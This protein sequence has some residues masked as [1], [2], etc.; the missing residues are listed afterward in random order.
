MEMEFECDGKLVKGYIP[1]YVCCPCNCGGSEP[2]PVTGIEV[3]PETAA[4]HVGD[5][6]QLTAT[7]SPANATDKRVT[8]SSSDPTVATV[9]A[10]GKVTAVS[11]GTVV[12][13][14]TTRD[15][16]HSASCTVTV[17]EKGGPGPEDPHFPEEG[18]INLY[19]GEALLGTYDT[20]EETYWDATDGDTMYFGEGT[21]VCDK[22]TEPTR[23]TNPPLGTTKAITLCGIAGKTIL[24]VRSDITGGSYNSLFHTTD[25]ESPTSQIAAVYRGF[26]FNYRRSEGGASHNHSIFMY[27]SGITVENCV[28][29]T[30]GTTSPAIAYYNYGRGHNNT[31]KNCTFVSEQPFQKSWTGAEKVDMY[32]CAFNVAMPA[33]IS[34]TG[35]NTGIFG[36]SVD[37]N[38]YKLNDADNSQYGVYSG[39]HAWPNP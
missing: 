18:R 30:P 10:N 17:S 7:V 8:W 32:N 37:Q 38:N 29:K 19:R 15:G 31:V 21:F 20:Y 24:E 14:A 11:E 4:L 25:T 9:D 36:V 16:G 33:D 26:I 35:K 27:C 12:I 6:L 3:D 23:W 28:I 39:P 2:V 13:T 34:A 22:A 5:T 1:I